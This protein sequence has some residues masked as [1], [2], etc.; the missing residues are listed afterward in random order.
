VR[1][2]ASASVVVAN[3][4]ER[5]NLASRALCKSVWLESVPVIAPHVAPP[6][7]GQIVQ[8]GKP[9]VRIKH[10]PSLPGVNISY[11][12]VV[13]PNNNPP[14]VVV[15]RPVPPNGTVVTVLLSQVVVATV[16][17]PLTVRQGLPVDP[18]NGI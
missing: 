2:S 15:E 16:P 14:A 9:L 12:L 10:S 1:P 6:P 17:L 18:R 11:K 8:T 3:H 13:D 5:L 4:A 7:P